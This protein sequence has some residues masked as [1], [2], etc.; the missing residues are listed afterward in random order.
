G[1]R[2]IYSDTETEW[3]GFWHGILGRGRYLRRGGQVWGSSAVKRKAGNRMCLV[4]RAA[5]SLSGGPRNLVRDP[6]AKHAAGGVEGE[7]ST[8]WSAAE[9][10]RYLAAPSYQLSDLEIRDLIAL[11]HSSGGRFDPVPARRAREWLSRRTGQRSSGS[12]DATSG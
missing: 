4:M 3:R 5:S 9:A 11:I 8:G 2:A 10:L 7:R 1:G 12:T 6:N